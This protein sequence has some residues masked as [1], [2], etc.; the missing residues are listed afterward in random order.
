MV[1]V[2]TVGSE[3]PLSPSFYLSVLT[4]IGSFATVSAGSILALHLQ[5]NTS[6]AVVKGISW[7]ITLAVFMSCFT[8][9]LPSCSSHAWSHTS[10]LA[11]A[12]H[13]FY[14][15]PLSLRAFYAIYGVVPSAL[16]VILL[17]R[18]CDSLCGFVISRAKS[19]Y[20]WHGDGGRR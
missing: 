20:E 8:T 17:V 2:S 13:I 3:C 6:A 4:T 11:T 18:H 10:P 7:E 9:M 12:Q 5:S 14:D 1:V 19:K 15:Y 16:Q